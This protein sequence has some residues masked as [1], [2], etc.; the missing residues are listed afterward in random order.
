VLVN[1]EK[2]AGKYQVNF[3]GKNLS[4]GLYF[5]KITTGKFTAVRKMLLI[6]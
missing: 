3:N 4:S 6:K 2:A 5:Y 1:E